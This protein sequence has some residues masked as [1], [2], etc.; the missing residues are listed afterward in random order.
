MGRSDAKGWLLFVIA[1]GVL[2]SCDAMFADEEPTSVPSAA[3][4]AAPM[5]SPSEVVVR[6]PGADHPAKPWSVPD[7]GIDGD[8]VDAGVTS[9]DGGESALRPG[10]E[11]DNASIKKALY[12]KVMQGRGS[13]DEIRLL[14]AACNQ[15]G[16]KACREAANAKLKE[17]MRE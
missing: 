7:A 15:L 5:P 11:L 12:G 14:E 16:D 2:A 6:A 4:T 9:T 3:V 13:I 1:L 8:A 17:K 10:M